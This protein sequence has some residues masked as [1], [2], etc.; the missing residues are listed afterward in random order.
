VENVSIKINY[1]KEGCM[2]SG[3]S[4]HK[5]LKSHLAPEAKELGKQHIY[6]LIGMIIIGIAIGLYNLN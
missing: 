2:G 5:V 1:D 3:K 6:I 4:K